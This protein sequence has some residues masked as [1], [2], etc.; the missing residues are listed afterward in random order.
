MIA[1]LLF[2]CTLDMSRNAWR[3]PA[4]M[5][6]LFCSFHEYLVACKSFKT[7]TQLFRVIGHYLFQSTCRMA[8]HSWPHPTYSSPR[9]NTRP[10]YKGG[11][12]VKRH[13]QFEVFMDT[14]LDAK[15]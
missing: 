9:A 10:K 2:L 7:I 12:R 15:N 4:Q 13:D 5:V 8:E 1:D 3:K 11:N 6:R 14:Q